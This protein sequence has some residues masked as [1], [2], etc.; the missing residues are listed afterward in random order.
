MYLSVIYSRRLISADAVLEVV[1]DALHRMPTM[2]G[3]HDRPLD[4]HGLLFRGGGLMMR[5]LPRENRRYE[6]MYFTAGAAIKGLTDMLR[7]YGWHEVWCRIHVAEVKLDRPDGMI[8]VSNPLFEDDRAAIGNATSV[9]Y[10]AIF[11]IPNTYIWLSVIRYRRPIDNQAVHD[12]VREAESS[13]PSIIRRHGDSPIG[14]R[15]LYFRNWDLVTKV[16]PVGTTQRFT[17]LSV[18]KVLVGLEL[19]LTQYGF[20]EIWCGVH[21]REVRP[22]NPDG[23]VSLSSHLPETGENDIPATI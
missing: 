21:I 12:L 13:L 15:G 1:R 4:A 16:Q 18:S 22:N 3:H 2:M 11:H 7:E 8:S 10:P 17:Y 6:I 23:L 5:V 9:F 14:P 20:H 19:L